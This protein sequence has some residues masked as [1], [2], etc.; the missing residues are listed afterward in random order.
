[1]KHTM[2]SKRCKKLIRFMMLATA[3]LLLT[4]A[5]S[6]AGFGG[7]A[8]PDFAP[9]Y[10]VGATNQDVH[11]SLLPVITGTDTGPVTLTQITMIPSC[12]AQTGTGTCASPD[13]GVFSVNPT[14]TG[15]LF[16]T[17]ISFT[18]AETD[19]VT[20]QV[21]FT[22]SST[23]TLSNLQ[24]CLIHFSI[25]VLQGPTTDASADPGV[26]TAQE[27]RF[28]MI[29]AA[30][31]VGTG[32][33]SD[34]TQIIFCGDGV[35]QAPETCDPPGS[36]PAGTNNTCRA[37][38]TYCG[39]GIT[40][41]G[42][43]CDY[44]NPNDPVTAAG[45]CSTTCTILPFC[46]DGVVNQASETCDPPGSIPAG[47]NNTCRADCTY[48]GDGITQAGEACDYNNPNDPIT[49]AH[50][51]STTCTVLPFCGD[52]VVNQR[53]ETC[54]PPGSTPAGTTNT[55]RADCTYCGDGTVQANDGEACEPPGTATCDANCQPI[56]VSAVCRTPG[57]WGTHACPCDGPCEEQGGSCAQNI[58]Q[59]VINQCDCLEVCGQAITNTCLNDASSAVE[60]ICVSPAGNITLQLVRQLTAM[61]LNCCVSGLSSNCSGDPGLASLFGECNGICTGGSDNTLTVQ[62]CINEIDC[63]NNGGTINESLKTL[64]QTGTCSDN[65]APCNSGDLS[66]CGTDPLHTCVALTDTC[67]NRAIPLSDLG[68]TNC[69]D[70]SGNPQQGSTGSSAECAAASLISNNNKPCPTCNYCAVI[71]LP[72]GVSCGPKTKF[73]PA[74]GQ[75]EQC[76][77][78]DSHPDNCPVSNPNPECT[79][80]ACGTFTPSCGPGACPNPICVATAEGGGL[81]AEA[82][83]PCAGLLPCTTSADCPSGA[84]CAVNTCCGTPVCAPAS[85]FCGSGAAA[86]AAAAATAIP[87]GPSI[88]GK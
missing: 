60:A 31:Q 11:L 83:T 79:A 25:N 59:A 12:G 38:C 44:N 4:V 55:C 72:A 1:M 82:S 87:S 22:P 3:M 18:I 51:C 27:A 43:A 8:T 29:K 46:G 84:L 68:L 39:D 33:G 58:T 57:F 34:L 15:D 47:T 36:I 74:V 52:G 76:C 7:S 32:T 81:C 10:T 80:A 65:S 50:H 69:L 61:S 5:P 24:E 88:G 45:H 71:P 35:V 41:A 40:Q 77:K 49:A 48:C 19:A 16:C 85:A 73:N 37:N 21:T 2:V 30:V 53:S 13:L 70:G 20:G 9:S 63:F 67:H 28:V 64:C 86:A 42:E 62:S 6:Y 75:G 17:G 66:K 78:T 54:D 56:K 26:Q 14:G 23:V